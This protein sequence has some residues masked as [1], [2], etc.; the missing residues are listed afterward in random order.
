M[1]SKAIG[2]TG[3]SSQIKL[4]DLETLLFFVAM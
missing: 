3:K 1:I 2:R 4:I